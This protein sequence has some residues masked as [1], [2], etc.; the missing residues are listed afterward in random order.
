MGRKVAPGTS[1]VL[2]S[3]FVPYGYL[4]ELGQNL[5]ATANPR[6]LA[7]WHTIGTMYGGTGITDFWLPNSA[8]QVDVGA[9][10]TGTGTLGNV[11]GNTGGEEAHLLSGAESGVAAHTHADSGHG[12]GTTE[13]NHSHSVET[14]G[15]NSTGSQIATA[16]GGTVGVGATDGAKTNLTINNGNAVIQPNLA[17]AASNAH[18]TLQPSLVATKAIKW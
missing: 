15:N 17:S 7:L 18:N 14:A 3:A 16:N 13:A 6:Y 12:H 9:G 10:G 2:R 5:N 8:R 1:I 11:V 4:A